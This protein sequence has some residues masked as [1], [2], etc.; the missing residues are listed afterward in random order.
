MFEKNEINGFFEG[1][2]NT[3]TEAFD[4]WVVNVQEV[5][6][7]WLD[8]YKKYFEVVMHCPFEGTVLFGLAKEW[9]LKPFEGFEAVLKNKEEKPKQKEVVEKPAL[10]IAKEKAP[11]TKPTVTVK[12]TPVVTKV[13]EEKKP[14][15]VLSALVKVVKEKPVVAK[16]PE[17]KKPAAKK[18]APKKPVVK[19]VVADVVT[20]L[21]AKTEKKVAPKRAQTTTE[22]K[23][24][25]PKVE[26]AKEVAAVEPPVADTNKAAE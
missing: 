11:V 15:S 7:F 6:T 17:V 14:E 1:L 19:N 2:N 5:S 26:V 25:V 4:Q 22:V 12:E 3:Y 21:I 18:A 16:K 10:V 13:A 23:V 8:L 24:D 9:K 20:P